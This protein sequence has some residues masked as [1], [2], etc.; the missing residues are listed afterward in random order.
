MPDITPAEM[1]RL[2][3]LCALSHSWSAYQQGEVA[4]LGLQCLSALR[5][6][7]ERAERAEKVCEAAAEYF[8]DRQDWANRVKQIGTPEGPIN[9]SL[10][11]EFQARLDREKLF[12]GRC[13][14]ALTAYRAAR[15]E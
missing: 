3:V 9:A 14:A 6:A 7:R 8:Q 10:A 2:E 1:A 11:L 5:E 12:A 4:G 15:G 13:A